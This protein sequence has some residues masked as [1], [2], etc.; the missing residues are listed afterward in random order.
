MSSLFPFGTMSTLIS[1]LK[2]TN[3][4]SNNEGKMDKDSNSYNVESR[5]VIIIPLQNRC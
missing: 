5:V 1:L 3:F 2:K 4:I